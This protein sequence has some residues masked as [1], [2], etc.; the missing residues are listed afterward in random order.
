MNLAAIITML[1]AQGTV[2]T[3]AAY[4]FYKVLT[5]PPKP[6]PDSFSENDDVEERQPE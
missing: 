1:L 4:F 3:L 2:V 5:T 6:E